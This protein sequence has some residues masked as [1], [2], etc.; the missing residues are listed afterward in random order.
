MSPNGKYMDERNP[1]RAYQSKIQATE[2]LTGFIKNLV[3]DSDSGLTKL[4]TEKIQSDAQKAVGEILNDTDV[5]DV[6]VREQDRFRQLSPMPRAFMRRRKQ[7][8]LYS[9][10]QAL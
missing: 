1:D 9:N 8:L 4:V 6:L 10:T 5:N 3:G 7:R 2:A